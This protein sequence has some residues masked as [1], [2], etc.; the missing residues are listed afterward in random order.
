[1]LFWFTCNGSSN[2][3]AKRKTVILS[4]FIYLSMSFQTH[5]TLKFQ[6]RKSRRFRLTEW[7]QYFCFK[8]TI[9]LIRLM[10]LF[11][12]CVECCIPASWMLFW[13]SCQT[14][15]LLTALLREVRQHWGWNGLG[16]VHHKIAWWTIITYWQSG[17]ET[18]SP[19]NKMR[20]WC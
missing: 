6:K 16:N 17:P 8:R 12:V 3:Y 5:L 11:W 20:F 9:S 1:M 4:S 2:R 7:W 18:S 15:M 13:A 10:I 19:A 14:K